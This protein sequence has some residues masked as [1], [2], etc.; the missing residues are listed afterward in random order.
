MPSETFVAPA[1]LSSIGRT[2][3]LG[4]SFGGFYRGTRVDEEQA[5]HREC[6]DWTHD[7]FGVNIEILGHFK[8]RQPIECLIHCQTTRQADPDGVGPTSYVM[9]YEPIQEGA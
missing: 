9:K 6:R 2:M 4:V 5:C 7:R 3:P 1:D 8:P